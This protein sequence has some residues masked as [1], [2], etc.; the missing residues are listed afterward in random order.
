LL[1]ILRLLIAVFK[2]ELKQEAVNANQWYMV[3]GS[4]A[5]SAALGWIVSQSGRVS[6]L[7]YLCVGVALISFW[8][9][10]VA[11]SGWA[12]SNELSGK[13]LDFT[14]I[15]R[16]PL[17]VVLYGKIIA[18]LV[19]ELP[20]G[21]I[22]ALSVLL[23]VRQIPQVIM[24]AYLPFSVLL[25]V[26][27]LLILT[28][29]LADLVILVGGK[30]GFFMGIVPFGAVLSGFILPV[31]QLPPGLEV[32]ARLLPTSWAMDAVWLSVTGT[33]SVWLIWGNWAV[34]VVLSAVW[35][36]IT[37][38]LANVVEKRIRVKGTIGAF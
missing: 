7:A 16:S 18:Q 6:V 2:K 12:L 30:S 5:T 11:I 37:L 8:R 20:G 26:A 28:S 21:I 24:P 9:G 17:P 19:Y 23:V 36:Y 1:N 35:F 22:S 38:R 14:L 25:A 4:A 13:T 27:G 10:T 32:V 29:F 33:D 34:A 15:S 31:Y 3:A